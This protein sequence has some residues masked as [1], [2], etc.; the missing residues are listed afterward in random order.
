MRSP[1]RFPAPGPTRPA[2]SLPSRLGATSMRGPHHPEPGLELVIAPA[3]VT[4]ESLPEDAV[5]RGPQKVAALVLRHC[6]VSG[7]GGRP[8]HD[9]H[10]VKTL[11]SDLG[12]HVRGGGFTRGGPLDGK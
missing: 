10:P 4:D 11:A 8:G 12:K 3:E 5:S 2:S 7:G 6:E 1:R 9:A